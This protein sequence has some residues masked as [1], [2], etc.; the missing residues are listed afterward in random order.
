MLYTADNYKNQHF[1]T[2][3]A[4]TTP[5]TSNRNISSKGK[6]EENLTGDKNKEEKSHTHTPPIHLQSHHHCYCGILRLTKAAEGHRLHLQ[7]HGQCMQQFL[8]FREFKHWITEFLSNQL[9][10]LDFFFFLN[11]TLIQRKKFSNFLYYTHKLQC[12]LQGVPWSLKTFLCFRWTHNI[13]INALNI[14]SELILG[15]KCQHRQLPIYEFEFLCLFCYS[16]TESF[17]LERK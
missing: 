2:N 4:V 8:H 1:A 6:W 14:G 15:F 10:L 17:R 5:E 13:N 11:K 7:Y 12:L 16:I 9:R 3:R